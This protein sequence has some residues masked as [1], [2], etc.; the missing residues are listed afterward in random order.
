MTSNIIMFWLV[1]SPLVVRKLLL[2][3]RSTDA[4]DLYDCKIQTQVK[5]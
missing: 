5:R 1:V 2:N 4:S 3:N